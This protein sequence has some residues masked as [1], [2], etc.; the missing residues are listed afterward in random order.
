MGNTTAA[1]RTSTWTL[2]PPP[3]IPTTT[4]LSMNT[5]SSSP[6]TETPQKSPSRTSRLPQRSLKSPTRLEL[7]TN[8]N[9]DPR[10]FAQPGILAAVIGG[11]VVG[12]LCAILLV[13]F[14]VYR[15]RKKDEGSY[16][17]DEPKRSPNVNSYS[18]PPSREFYA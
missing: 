1:V 16:A 12:L 14:I 4:S 2:T 11:A 15:M 9:L 10:F 5:T 3:A 7:S 13:M 8:I 18:K 17:L 6:R